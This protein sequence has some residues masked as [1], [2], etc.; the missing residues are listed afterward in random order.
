MN[1]RL[2][3][4]VALLF[5]IWSLT[6]CASF[7]PRGSHTPGVYHQVKSGE[8]L[9]SIAQTYQ[10]KVKELA[11]ANQ[12]QLPESLEAGRVIFVP[13]ARFPVAD[14]PGATKEPGRVV[15][16]PA[17]APPAVV[18]P[19]EARPGP[20][21][22][23]KSSTVKPR[24]EV[25]AGKDDATRPPPKTLSQIPRAV[26]KDQPP[27]DKKRFIW[28]VKGEIR[29]RFGPQPG[30]MFFNGIKIA[31]REGTPVVA[32]AS[33]Q[34]IFSSNLKDFGETIL[35]RHEDNFAT[36]YT[37]L[38]SRLVKVSDQVKIGEQIG[39]MG[40]AERGGEAILNFEIRY[41][42]K[43]HNPLLFLP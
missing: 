29:S 35:L 28:P 23:E 26:D 25:S 31:A 15:R 5:V 36:V 42:N 8:T 9:W 24:E 16:P 39:V 41:R 27:L 20:V 21:E 3:I 32:A 4:T 17:Q 7:S 10:V 40:G 12:I 43:A 37:N 2:P 11:D 30:G 19:E 22:P 13:G 34:V 38:G 1:I 33:G 6:A 18:T 14:Q